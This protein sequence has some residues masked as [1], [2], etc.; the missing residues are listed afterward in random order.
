ME[1]VFLKMALIY[2]PVYAIPNPRL[3][4]I[5]MQQNIAPSRFI[6]DHAA[7][8]LNNLPA[9]VKNVRFDTISRSSSLFWCII[10]GDGRAID[11]RMRYK[12]LRKLYGFYISISKSIYFHS[13]WIGNIKRV[14]P[15]YMKKY[16]KFRSE[17]ISSDEITDRK[18]YLTFEAFRNSNGYYGFDVRVNSVYSKYMEDMMCEKYRKCSAPLYTEYTK[19]TECTRRH[20]I[21]KCFVPKEVRTRMQKMNS[22]NNID[23]FRFNP[24]QISM[25]NV[26][27]Q[28]SWRR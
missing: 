26:K 6:L 12:Q 7:L 22:I 24:I 16:Y 1:G 10:I 27:N 3:I 20:I 13:Y 18:S 28:I 23:R 14:Y 4:R 19:K 11:Y 15:I 8:M 21:S 17:I 5:N 2:D 9:I 25:G